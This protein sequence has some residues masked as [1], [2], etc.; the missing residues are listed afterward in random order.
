MSSSKLGVGFIGSGFVAKFHLEA[1]R[2]VRDADVLGVYSPNMAHAE[3]TAARARELRVGNARAFKSIEEM[4]AA[5][6]IDCVWLCGPNHMRVQNME[7]I[8]DAVQSGTGKLIGVACEK[9]LARNVAEAK[10]MVQLV[11]RSGLLHGYLEDQ[12]F[13]PSVT[14][15]RKVMWSRAAALTGRPYLARAA[16]EHSGPH[17]PWFWRGELQGGGVLNDMMCHSIEVGRFMLTKPGAARSSS[18]AEGVGTDCEFEMVST[19]LCRDSQAEHG[20]RLQ[21]QSSRRFCTSDNQLRR[22]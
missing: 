11:E 21:E 20:C 6:E 7:A 4:I 13:A 14:R 22:R 12:I 8:C 2:G 17:A 16:E 5:P 10:R 9:P 15:G 3:A 19:R 1:W 18:T